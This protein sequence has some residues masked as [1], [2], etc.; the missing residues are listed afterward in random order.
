RLTAEGR[1]LHERTQT[2]LRD[3]EDVGHNIAAG[4]DQP[5]GVLRVSAPVLFSETFA[6]RLACEFMIQYP[7]VRLEWSALDR[8]VDPVD[9]GFDVVI[10]INPNPNSELVGR[11]FA[12]DTMLLVAPPDLP[13]PE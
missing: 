13:M 1:L 8:L 9:E 3:I 11:R 12:R 4:T 10:R 7:E 6:G 2:L 5:R